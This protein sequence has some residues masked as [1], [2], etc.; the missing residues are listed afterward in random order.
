MRAHRSR[1]IG[2]GRTRRQLPVNALPLCPVD[3]LPDP[4]SRGFE[5]PTPAGPL[6]CLLVHCAGAFSAYLNQCPH[7]GA[8]LDW[9]PDQ[10]LD[11]AGKLIQCALHGALFLPDTGECVHG[12]CLGAYLTGIPVTLEGGWV[13]IPRTPGALPAP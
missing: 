10:F 8:P 12:P 3:A 5:L 4:G 1:R 13:H 2:G 9:L 11:P 7:T 6:E